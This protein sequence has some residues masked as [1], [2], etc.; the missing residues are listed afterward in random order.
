MS[1]KKQARPA[2]V[3]P[4]RRPERCSDL[5]SENGRRTSRLLQ[6]DK[7]VNGPLC[8]HHPPREFTLGHAK[9]LRL[10]NV[11]VTRHAWRSIIAVYGYR[12]NRLEE[13][14]SAMLRQSACPVASACEASALP[15]SYAPGGLH[16]TCFAAWYPSI[17]AGKRTGRSAPRGRRRGSGRASVTLARFLGWAGDK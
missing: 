16:F 8:R 11:L 17:E 7:S 3:A 9:S 15:L 14:G 1:L 4:P 5:W 10:G 12:R 13:C 2:I 6:D